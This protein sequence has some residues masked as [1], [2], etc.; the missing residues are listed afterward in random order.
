MTGADWISAHVH[1]HG[2]LDGLLV[3]GLRPLLVGLREAGLVDRAFFLRHWQGGPHLR[4]RLAPGEGVDRAAVIARLD[5]AMGRFLDERPSRRAVTDAEYRSVAGRLAATDPRGSTV[6]P[7]EPDN[8]VRHRPYEREYDRYGGTDAAM[9]AVED[10]FC[11]SSALVLDV[12][13][14]RPDGNRRNGQAL[15]MITGSAAMAT[16]DGPELARF[17]HAGR[18]VWG[19]TLLAGDETAEAL[20][21]R[22]WHRQRDGVRRIVD[23]V[24]GTVRDEGY[25]DGASP[26]ARWL[27]SLTALAARLGRLADDGAFAPLDVVGPRVRGSGLPSVLLLCSHLNTNRL[28]VPVTEEA[29]LMY[30]LNRAVLGDPS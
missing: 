12:L 2:D 14:G 26:V 7:L 11:E 27:R 18:A 24:V 25:R 10:H 22:R 6:E 20:F 13:S 3:D 17:A 21:E 30:L 15:A 1:Y 16:D 4:V 8:T 5:A 23:T 9:D 19:R 29:Y 28:G